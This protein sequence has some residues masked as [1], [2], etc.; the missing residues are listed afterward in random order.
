MA[1]LFQDQHQ[2]NKKGPQKTAWSVGWHEPDGTR[3]QKSFGTGPDGKK[4]AFRFKKRIEAELLTGAY[5]SKKRMLWST[6]REEYG[7]TIL[8][9]MS[10]ENQRCINKALEHFERIVKP[11]YVDLVNAKRIDKYVSERRTERGAKK[12]TT[13]SPAS[14]N[15]EL[16]HLKSVFG[17]AKEWGCLTAVPRIKMLREPD[18]IK[19]YMTPEHLAA[20]YAACEVAARPVLPNVNPADWWRALLC[21]LS[22]TGWRIDE[23]F[24]LKSSDLDLDAGT[25]ITRHS[26]NKGARDEA[27]ALHSV[28]IE[29]LRSI[30]GHFGEQVFEYPHGHKQ[31][32]TEFHLIQDAAGIDLPCHENHEHTPACHH[33]GF[34]DIRRAFAT[35]NAANVSA[36]ELQ[37]LMRH[38]A[39]S[40]TQRYIN[41]AKQMQGTEAK[42]FV[43]DVLRK[44]DAG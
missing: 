9:G 36:V 25:A 38:K 24:Q 4:L 21:F 29:H 42:L 41:M 32:W 43:P 33:Y 39:F 13:V 18:K 5:E 19:R 15:K 30:A 1:W 7:S 6:F 35:M 17:V 20:I 3:R 37:S 28:V 14:I 16:R 26:D 34:H 44:G 27:V 22:M 10:A 31:K 8:S 2:L 23:A 40:T 11:H 12:G